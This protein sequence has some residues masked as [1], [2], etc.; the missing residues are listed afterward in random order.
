MANY[1]C[2][3]FY[4]PPLTLTPPLPSPLSTLGALLDPVCP[5][6]GAEV[7]SPAFFGLTKG[8]D[9]PHKPLP[10]AT[11]ESFPTSTGASCLLLSIPWVSGK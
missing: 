7:H 3:L 5:G 4:V 1:F 11:P 9:Y 2:E 8:T 10:P 6:Q